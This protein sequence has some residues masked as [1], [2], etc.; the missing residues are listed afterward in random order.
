MV[1]QEDTRFILVREGSLRPVGDFYI[2]SGKIQWEER[3]VWTPGLKG[4]GE[5]RTVPLKPKKETGSS[6][7]AF[8]RAECGCSVL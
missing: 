7:R 5:R 2:V 6:K 1:A 4:S 3:G 8:A